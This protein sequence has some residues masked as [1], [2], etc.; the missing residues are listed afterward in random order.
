MAVRD[1]A[2]YNAYMREYVLARYHRRRL[3]WVEVKG[4]RCVQC[5]AT[6]NLEFDH[7]DA[8]TKSATISKLWSMNDEIIEAELE[9]C[10]LL[11]H[12]HHMEKSKRDDDFNPWKNK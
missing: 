5:G 2:K 4:G 1:K 11:C 9:K 7:I 6:D 12:D 8:A 10:Q 3:E